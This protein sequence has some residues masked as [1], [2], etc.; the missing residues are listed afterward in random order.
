[1]H[2]RAD[3]LRPAQDEGNP[4][5]R[6]P[7]PLRP[8]LWPWFLLGLCVTLALCVLAIEFVRFVDIVPAGSETSLTWWRS[9]ALLA[10][11]M[12]GMIVTAT[13]VVLAHQRRM[14]DLG[15]DSSDRQLQGIALALSNL[16]RDP[17]SAWRT[18]REE[19][20]IDGHALW[21]SEGRLV[22]FSGFLGRYL[23][24]LADWRTP[25]VRQ[26][27]T[28][29]V[30]GGHM[31]PPPGLN[32]AQTIEVYCHL[33]SRIPGLRELRM[34]DGQ[35]FLARTI[36]LG[37]GRLA[38]VYTNISELY[39]SRDGMVGADTFRLA[40]EQAP[41][42]KLMLDA[43]QR[44]TAVNNAFL[45]LMGYDS[46][47][48]AR[49]GW[50]GLLAEDENRDTLPWAAGARRMVTADGE[51][52]RVQISVQNLVDPLSD[53][54]GGTLVTLEDV[55]GRWE[56]EERLRLQAAILDRIELAVLAVDK[57]GRVVHG[58]RSV[59]A[60]FQWSEQV[61]PGT[62]VER[63]LGAS[64][65]N[66]DDGKELETEGTTW[67]GTVFP[68]QVHV[69]KLS[70]ESVL[71]EGTILV[72]ADLTPRRALDLQLMH[73]A[74]LATLGE[75][76][77]SIAHE[78]NQCLHVIRLASEAVQMDIGDGHLNIERLR[79]RTSNIL[80]QVDRL[81]EM[82]THMRAISRRENQDRKPF[83]PQ[84]AVDSALRMVEPLLK[85][86]GIRVIRQGCLEKL[87]VLGHQV[88]L[89]QVLLNLLNNGRDAIRDRFRAHGNSGGT[90]TITCETDPETRRLR[91]RVRDDGTG[92][93]KAIGDH[94]FEPFVTTKDG[95][96]GL[97]LGLSIS[98]GICSE[99][100]GCLSF[101]NVENGAEFTI[102]LPLA[103]SDTPPPL[104]APAPPPLPTSSRSEDKLEG[105]DEDEDDFCA[106]QRVL[107][108]DD[109]AL[110][111][112]MLAEFLK[113]HGYEVDTAYDGL[114]AYELCQTHVYHA[115]IT[116]IRM[117]RM[118][119]REL[120]AKLEELQPGTPVI[121]VTG[122]LK[123][124]NAA[125]LGANVVAL[126]AK[127]F[128]LQDLREHLLRLE[129]HP[130]NPQEEGV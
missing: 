66:A 36:D 63:L 47:V 65:L 107:L 40:F 101:G 104:C 14:L 77:A 51:T 115:V 125:D 105:E 109:E 110:S 74:R 28:A 106:G 11:V 70:P 57:S 89:E 22:D 58:N 71:P 19:K 99:M 20:V 55:G 121:V 6:G 8:G 100:G 126:L 29:M 21:D 122:H 68:A 53:T 18:L 128:Q 13:V 92:I 103:P 5:Q 37:H 82:V 25:T 46:D 81:T 31:L 39:R 113:R 111:V 108:V 88:R 72:V 87:L 95:G 24:Q 30:D 16:D 130:H 80:D 102:D 116:D 60:L 48:A 78:F 67:S 112:M 90:I 94:I 64:V 1:M 50:L 42:A 38:S 84:A 12:A 10:A 44:P 75:M 15:R 118:T 127:P 56:S 62:P 35:S 26:L 52:V 119:G 91:I 124:N 73:S 43:Q 41:N 76:A 7:S 27:I 98:R 93:A 61:L 86:D 85:A 33:R 129:H 96:N 9:P 34:S 123:E 2:D 114:E 4:G 120:I 69:S 117:P 79:T 17:L 32:R 49:L 54:P 23:P 83:R 3:R 45:A 59:C 97:G